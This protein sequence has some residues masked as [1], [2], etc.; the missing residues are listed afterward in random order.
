[1]PSTPSPLTA[2]TPILQE[3]IARSLAFK[4]SEDVFARRATPHALRDLLLEDLPEQ[5]ATVQAIWEDIS[6][7]LLPYCVNMNSP[8]FMG[9]GDTGADPA[10]LVAGIFAVLV[11]QNLINQSFCSPSG[12]MAEI[13]VIRWLRDLIGYPTMPACEVESVWEAGGITTY[14]GTGSNTTAMMLAREHTVPGTLTD[15]VRDPERFGLVVPR[16]VGHYSVKSAAAWT[17]CGTHLIEVDTDHFR[18]DLTALARA[19]KENA[20]RLM[21]VVAYA[22]DSRTQTI[23]HLRA[24]HDTVRTVD[25]SVWLHADACW[26]LMAALT[27]RRR[28]LLDGIEAFDSVT[29]DPH[30]VLNVPYAT[31]ALLVRDPASLRMVSSYSDLIMQEDYAFGQVTP[32]LGTKEWTSLRAWA[33]LRS[34]G[35]QGLTRMMDDRLD[36]TAA[37]A[38]LVDAHPQL[39]RLH[40]P[41]L[42]AVA[43]C[44]LP[45]GTHPGTATDT[46]VVR[47]NEVNRAI[48]RRLMDEGRWHLHQFTLPDDHGH[49]RRGAVLAP[50]RFMSINPRITTTHM[51]DVLDYVTRLGQEASR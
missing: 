44:Y 31:S 4:D 37:F 17:G 10:S 3:V 33:A 11:Q 50:L 45:P 14:G 18:Y 34:Q 15:G 12:T 5:P 16:G 40:E 36:R 9:F 39:M 42:C 49:I 22:G 25:P 23:D 19:V 41:D 27:P 32:Q 30:K 1:M 43:F 7:R 51:R 20:G 13:A 26:G 24:V 47:L 35:R 38:M 28:H 6:K 2:L 46:Q 8:R 48:H 29:V 21:A